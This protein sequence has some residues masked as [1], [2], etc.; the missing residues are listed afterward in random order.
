MECVA[1]IKMKISRDEKEI[2]I[3][4]ESRMTG[5]KS[6]IF[7]ERGERGKRGGRM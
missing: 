1:E 3:M 7:Q 5:M 4:K 6:N 2:K